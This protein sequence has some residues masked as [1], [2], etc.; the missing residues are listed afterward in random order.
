VCLWPPHL[1]V[2]RF[3]REMDGQNLPL[4]KSKNNGESLLCIILLECIKVGK[5]SRNKS[6]TRQCMVTLNFVNYTKSTT[7]A[8]L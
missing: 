2:A 7:C 3:R 5:Y 6:L 8:S 1:Q 4:S